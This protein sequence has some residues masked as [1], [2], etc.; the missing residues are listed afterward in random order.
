MIVSV[1]VPVCWRTRSCSRTPLYLPLTVSWLIP[2]PFNVMFVC[3]KAMA[4]VCSEIVLQARPVM[5]MVSPVAAAA[6]AAR[7]LPAPLSLQLETITLLAKASAERPL[8]LIV[9]DL[10]WLDRASAE[11]LGFAAHRLAGSR[12]GLLTASR[13]HDG[14]DSIG[15]LPPQLEH[16]A[17]GLACH[18]E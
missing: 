6:A 11:V 1:P 10:P 7:K 3:D 4:P 12:I 14:A 15:L 8:L 2:G 16:R 13:Q 18:D 5:S 17:Q 9:D